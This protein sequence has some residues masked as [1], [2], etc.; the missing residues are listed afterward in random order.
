M[1]ARILGLRILDHVIVTKKG[2]FDFR[3][4]GSEKGNR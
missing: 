4:D 3:E 2:Y 1:A